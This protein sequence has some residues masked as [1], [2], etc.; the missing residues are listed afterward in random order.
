M[1]NNRNIKRI[2][3]LAAIVF[4]IALGFWLGPMAVELF[5]EMHGL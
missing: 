3:V 4:I 1:E 2:A 5:L